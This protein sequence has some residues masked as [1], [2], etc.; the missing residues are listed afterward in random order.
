MR[1][2]LNE[3]TN[4]S[5]LIPSNFRSTQSLG[6]YLREQKIVGIQE[7]DTRMLT[8]ILRNQ[9][10]MNGIISTID[11]DDTSLLQKVRFFPSMD[12]LDCSLIENDGINYYKVMKEY[13]FNYD[14][15]YKNK[16]I[17][18]MFLLFGLMVNVIKSFITI[19]ISKMKKLNQLC[20]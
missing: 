13:S 7:I 15:N 2:V 12:G 4:G 17:K 10:T 8:R 18:V 1:W 16:L 5:N 9:G 19:L 11:L 14:R 20:L 6:E 3:M